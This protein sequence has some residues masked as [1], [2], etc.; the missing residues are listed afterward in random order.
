L[1]LLHRELLQKA[2]AAGFGDADNSAV[3]E[4]FRRSGNK[5]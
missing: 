4:V 5:T 3:I 2:E 1:S